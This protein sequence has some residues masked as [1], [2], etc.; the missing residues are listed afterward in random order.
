MTREDIIRMAREVGGADITVNGFTT[1]VGTQST[2]FLERFAAL[3]AEWGA[4]QEREA[5]AQACEAR[6]MGDN[7]R[8][9]A[10]AKRCAA[11]IRSR[12]EVKL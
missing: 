11:A 12:G 6:N 4:K 7:N 9:D 1:W 8:E 3:A 10:E 2:E 5:C